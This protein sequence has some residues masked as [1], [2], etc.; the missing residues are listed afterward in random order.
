MLPLL[1]S[2]PTLLPCRLDP[3]LVMLYWFHKISKSRINIAW[4]HKDLK[5]WDFQQIGEVK[6]NPDQAKAKAKKIKE[7]S[8]SLSL[9]LRWVHKRLMERRRFRFRFRLVWVHPNSDSSMQGSKVRGPG[10]TSQWE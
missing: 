8:K 1:G 2:E 6:V 3:Y 7:K 9:S 10:F 4:P 5:G